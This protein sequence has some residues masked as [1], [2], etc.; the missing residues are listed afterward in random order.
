MTYS[1]F[2]KQKEFL[3]AFC[4]DYARINEVSNSMLEITNYMQ[5]SALLNQPYNLSSNIVTADLKQ[6]LQSNT[7]RSFEYSQN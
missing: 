2:N 1:K 5:Y 7:Y 3:G 6:V 4:A